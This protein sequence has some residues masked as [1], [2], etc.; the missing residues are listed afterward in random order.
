[1]TDVVAR[2]SCPQCG[3]VLPLGRGGGTVTCA[4]CG[5]SS[6]YAVVAAEVPTTRTL[7]DLSIVPLPASRD[8]LVAGWT[9]TT[10][11]AR[12][13]ATG[14]T[15]WTVQLPR[16]RHR[17]VTRFERLYVVSEATEIVAIDAATGR[18]AFTSSLPGP[19]TVLD[20]RP[21]LADVAGPSQSRARVL[22]HAAGQLLALDRMSG[23]VGDRWPAVAPLRCWQAGEERL[24]CGP[25]GEAT[26]LVDPQ[27]P[28]PL[29]QISC[30]ARAAAIAGAHAFLG[31]TDEVIAVKVADGAIAWRATAAWDPAIGLRAAFAG[32]LVIASGDTLTTL[33]GGKAITTP[34]PIDDV[35]M[36]AGTVITRTRTQ[37]Q[38]YQRSLAPAWQLPLNEFS[39]VR[40]A[41]NGRMLVL[42]LVGTDQ[43]WLRGLLPTTGKT[44]W[45]VLV[46][47]AAGPA[48]HQVV[49][50]YVLVEVAGRSIVLRADSG[51]ICLQ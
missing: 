21:C 5:L 1:M 41:D 51:Q 4:F 22:V 34:D 45:N 27:R 19:V 2:G 28:A 26:W 17:M 11:E 36:V 33:P 42:A 35:A 24:V 30:D 39:A 32:E 7:D 10:L 3:A 44:R 23:G 6:T 49:G 15:V 43:V 31:T 46:P 38:A 40:M 47:D 8:V 25:V 13:P 9:A 14:R 18:V 16:S 48:R 29:V 37:I 50:D 20:D 12:E